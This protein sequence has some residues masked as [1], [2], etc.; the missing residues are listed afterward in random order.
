MTGTEL[1][2]VYVSVPVRWKGGKSQIGKI[3]QGSD[4]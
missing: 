3:L 4:I 2:L 1:L